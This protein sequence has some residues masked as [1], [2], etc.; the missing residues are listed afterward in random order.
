[1][2]FSGA[3]WFVVAALAVFAG[4]GVLHVLACA[5]RDETR[6]HDLR[7][8]VAALRREQLERLQRL[9]ERAG[10]VTVD[11]SL[12]ASLRPVQPHRKAA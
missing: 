5:V 6:V 4:L 8:R 9:A 11:E 7:V 3:L 12:S 1:M 10:A 2:A